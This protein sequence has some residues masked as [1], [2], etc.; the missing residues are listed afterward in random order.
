MARTSR[1]TDSMRYNFNMISTAYHEAGHAIFSLIHFMKVP[2]VMVFREKRTKKIGGWTSYDSL[3]ESKFT[4][5]LVQSYLIDSEIGTWFAGAVAERNCF[6]ILSGSNKYPYYI[7]YG[8]T[9]DNKAAADLIKKLNPNLQTSQRTKYKNKIIKNV[10]N[11]IKTYWSDVSLV[12][13]S[14]F[15]KKKL[16]FLELKE[17]LTKKSSNKKYWKEQF[18]K[19]ERIHDYSHLVNDGDLK[20]LC[21]LEP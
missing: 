2:L 13:Y 20:T 3:D 21:N 7:K 18:K 15:D 8:A 10:T 5:P 14:L 17:L 1:V 12:A 9:L 6:K 4:D 16:S 11:D 19:I